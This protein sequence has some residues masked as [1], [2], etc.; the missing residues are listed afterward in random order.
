MSE[1]DPD[2]I[3]LWRAEG[4]S[5]AEIGRRLGVSAERLRDLAGLSAP[6]GRDDNR[7]NDGAEPR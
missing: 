6:A 3:R 5:D 7:P 4:L 1:L 2:L